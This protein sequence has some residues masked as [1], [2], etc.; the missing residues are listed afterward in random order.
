MKIN[1]QELLKEM[2]EDFKAAIAAEEERLLQEKIDKRKEK[3]EHLLNNT[4]Y[5]DEE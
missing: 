4:A 1:Y 2:K 5:D 3:I